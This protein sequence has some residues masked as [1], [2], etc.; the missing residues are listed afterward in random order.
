MSRQYCSNLANFTQEKCRD[1]IEQ[2]DNIVRKD[3]ISFAKIIFNWKDS[4]IFA[5][6]V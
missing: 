4:I 1:N 3:S 6:I 2:K 5:T